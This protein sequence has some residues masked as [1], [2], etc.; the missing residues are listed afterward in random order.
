MFK[1]ENSKQ[2]DFTVVF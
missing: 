1:N 2:F